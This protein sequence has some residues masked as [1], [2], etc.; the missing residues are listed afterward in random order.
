MQKRVENYNMRSHC[1]ECKLANIKILECTN[2]FSTIILCESISMDFSLACLP[3]TGNIIESCNIFG[4]ILD[5][6]DHNFWSWIVT[7][8]TLLKIIV[9]TFKLLIVVLHSLSSK[10]WWPSRVSQQKLC[11][12]SFHLRT[13]EQI[14]GSMLTYFAT[15]LQLTP[16][17]HMT[18][19]DTPLLCDECMSLSHGGIDFNHNWRP[20]FQDLSLLYLKIPFIKSIFEHWFVQWVTFHLRKYLCS[21]IFK[22][23]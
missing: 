14:I 20:Q 19:W 13:I 9:K 5:S 1:N 17:L 6:H 8:Q 15:Q 16:R 22:I 18:L 12:C 7:S 23:L 10:H 11:S 3:L 2:L 4:A 21:T